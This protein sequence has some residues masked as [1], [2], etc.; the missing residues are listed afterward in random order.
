[1]RD[2]AGQMVGRQLLAPVVGAAYLGKNT[3]PMQKTISGCEDSEMPGMNAENDPSSKVLTAQETTAVLHRILHA[4]ETN[5]H[6]RW[7][8]IACAI[9]LSLATTASAWCAYQSTLWGGVQLFRLVA[10]NAAS[11]KAS[12]LN[13]TAL[14][15]RAFDIA[16]GL[17]YMEAVFR[18]DKKQ[19]DFLRGRFRPE[20]K[21]AMDA[22][23]ATDPLNN[24][25]AP[26]GPFIMAEYVQ[27]ELIDAKHQNDMA[28]QQQ[29]A[30]Q[31]ANEI[32]DTYVLL[33][34]L[35][36]S[37]L[38]FGGIGGT[39]QSSRL[40]SVVFVIA[41]AL[42]AVTLVTLGTLPICNE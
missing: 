29:A 1:M 26:R 6:R 15:Y 38:F 37:V 19:E 24:P 27:Q 2:S 12:E 23:L 17:S 20:L 3:C 28:A 39:F 8:E 10:A 25:A 33:T 18:A 31:S 30:A 22:W 14:Q 40:R 41:L 9:V 5:Q 7:V 11:R 21:K 35:F 34:V 16:I 42:F 32:S 13:I 36:A 4:V